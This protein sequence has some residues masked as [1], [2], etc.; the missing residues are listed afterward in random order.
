MCGGC[1]TVLIVQLLQVSMQHKHE[2]SDAEW[3]FNSPRHPQ[4][5]SKGA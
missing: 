2:L 1:N 4:L 5:E 3:K